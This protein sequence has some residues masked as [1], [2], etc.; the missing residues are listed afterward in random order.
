MTG[1]SGD[2]SLVRAGA[3]AIAA[4]R[5]AN[6]TT[7]IAAACAEF[8][9]LDLSGANLAGASLRRCHFAACDLRQASF[10]GAS[11]A[12]AR[13]TGCDLTAVTFSD[14]DLRGAALDDVKLDGAR[15]DGARALGRLTA[16]R[17]SAT[18]VTPPTYDRIAA[19]LIDRWLGWDRLR[20][21]ATIRIFVPAYASLTLSVIYLNAVAWYNEAVVRLNE[22][23]SG[24]LAKAHFLAFAE[25]SPGWTHIAVV[26]DFSLLA[27]AATAFL[28][29]P[30][31][32]VEFSRE[33]WVSEMREPELLYDHAVWQ[34]LWLRCL[35][36]AS[37]GLGGAL[38]ALLLGRAI[39]EQ[40]YFI[41]VH[42][43]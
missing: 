12:G 37:L 8:K 30:A 3:G 15:F 34:R 43:I 41:L 38:G 25:A 27:I 23:A 35:C 24:V 10:A 11:L 22:A 32:V 14:A 36:A 29:C 42:V 20:F 7:T 16:L 19:P 28:R 18:P 39:V 17:L 9:R 4:W 40:I 1:Q 2:A 5:A 26:V 6:P 21:L 31:R 13:F 33:R